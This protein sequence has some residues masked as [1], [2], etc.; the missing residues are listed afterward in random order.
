ML[1]IQLGQ[2][3]GWNLESNVVLPMEINVPQGG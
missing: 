1:P 2:G 3:N